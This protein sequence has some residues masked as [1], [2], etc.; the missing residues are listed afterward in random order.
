MV[1]GKLIKNRFLFNFVTETKSFVNNASCKFNTILT[2][3]RYKNFIFI[4]TL[5]SFFDFVNK[6]IDFFNKQN[7]TFSINR[8]LQKRITIL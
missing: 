5:H 8:I 7:I 2:K 6:L 3:Y 1:K 4:F